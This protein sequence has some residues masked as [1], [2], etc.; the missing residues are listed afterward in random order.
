MIQM[1]VLD[2]ADRKLW[3]F[4]TTLSCANMV[5]VVNYSKAQAS[6]AR[7]SSKLGDWLSEWLSFDWVRDFSPWASSAMEAV[8]EMKFG[9]KVA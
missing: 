9:P 1:H 5:E 6:V 8:K 4:Y 2:S 7:A 3:G